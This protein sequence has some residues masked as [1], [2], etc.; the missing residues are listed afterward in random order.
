MPCCGVVML[1]VKE[2]EMQAL[3]GLAPSRQNVGSLLRAKASQ[4]NYLSIAPVFIY[5]CWVSMLIL[6]C[7]VSSCWMTFCR[8]SLY[9]VLLYCFLLQWVS[10]SLNTINYN[11]DKRTPFKVRFIRDHWEYNRS[12]VPKIRNGFKLIYLL[13]LLGAWS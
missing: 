10:W 3:G 7:W 5:Y 9:W 2:G 1:P 12:K 11:P 6:L 13:Y 4:I 8:V